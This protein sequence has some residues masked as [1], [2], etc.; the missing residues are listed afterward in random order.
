MCERPVTTIEIW[1]TLSKNL[2]AAAVTTTL[3]RHTRA[4]VD[5][6]IAFAFAVGIFWSAVVG[7]LNVFTL[8]QTGLMRGL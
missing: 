6:V 7:L 4:R 3:C 8:Q 2:T 5:A 1:S